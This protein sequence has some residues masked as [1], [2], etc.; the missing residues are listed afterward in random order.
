MAEPF[1]NLL[2]A[3]VVADMARHLERVQ[4]GF[5]RARF[6]ALALQGLDALELKAR[7]LHLCSALEH[8]LPN[9]FAQAAE[10]MEAALAPTHDAGTGPMGPRDSGLAGWAVWPLTEYV[11]R[12]GLAQPERALHA[13]HAMTQRFTSEWAVRPYLLRH[14]QLSFEHLQ[15]WVHDD[16]AHVRRWVSEGSRP[17]LPWG[18]VLKPLVE[19]PSPTLPLLEALM[20]DPSEYVRKSVANHLNDIAK[21]HPH[22]V[23][24]W[25]QRH[26]PGAPPER[27]RLLKHACRTLI[28]SGHPG[29]MQAF[30]VGERLIGT[31]SLSV[32]PTQVAV[33]EG[34]QIG[35]TVQSTAKA[36][37]RLAIDYAVHHVKAN[38]STSPKVFKGWGLLLPAFERRE[39]LKRHSLKPITTRT[40]YP[41]E[42]RV[43]LMV[44]GQSV[45]S[46]VFV[47]TLRP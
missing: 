30:G 31:V 2:N 4:P 3:K 7:A 13:L 22:I 43:E 21:D 23:E 18:M 32:S 33:G 19:D 45:G 40:Y 25:V 36:A 34:V 12:H 10:L 42:H 44:N 14:P 20:D 17:R 5:E 35:V 27:Q 46:A 38:G 11:A 6:E 24:A 41:G 28:K 15:R 37:Q 1:K 8:T 26:L 9:D 47:L 16:S 39:L 29:V